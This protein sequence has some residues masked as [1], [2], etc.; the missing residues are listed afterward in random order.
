MTT[1]CRFL[2]SCTSN[3]RDP[4][5][6]HVISPV[7]GVNVEGADNAKMLAARSFSL[8]FLL[9]SVR[10]NASVWAM[11]SPTCTS[12]IFIT[13]I[14]IVAGE[15]DSHAPAARRTGT[16]HGVALASIRRMSS[17]LTR[18]VDLF[19]E[20]DLDERLIRYVAFT[21]HDL[22]PLKQRVR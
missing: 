18:S 3:A 21:G 12:F 7:A 6:G 2:R 8:S 17:L 9:F 15:V 4:E 14:R 22:D 16:C 19:R 20:P 5:T 13:I 10:S 1:A 11:S